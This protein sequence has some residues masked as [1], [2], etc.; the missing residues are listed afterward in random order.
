MQLA[1]NAF[2]AIA[3]SSGLVR[4][5]EK[6]SPQDEA[7]Y[8]QMVK[9]MGA[10]PDAAMAATKQVDA[11]RKWTEV[12]GGL[13]HYHIEGTFQGQVNVVGGGTWVGYADVTD[14]VVIDLD[15]NLSQSR[16]AGTPRIQNTKA[17][18]RNPRNPEPKCLPP[19]LKGDYEHY[20][21]IGIKD[22][23][24]G[25]LEFQVK[26]SYPVVE[27]AQNCSGARTRV[28]ASVKTRPEAFVMLSPVLLD[29]R[30]PD[31]DNLRVSK[32]RKSMIHK[33]GGWTW[34]Y[35]PSVGK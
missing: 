25:A 16:L 17:T 11:S 8:R 4:A 3:L 9:S 26:T 35:T 13:I 15:W 30:V 1:M 7:L 32:D 19:M 31:S 12:K 6:M 22:G 2:L 27:V 14:R 29:S 23:A 20:D 34:T 24:G 33:Q 18:T 28:P 21:L 10:N 5:Q